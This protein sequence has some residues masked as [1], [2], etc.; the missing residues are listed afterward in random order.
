[1]QSG[2]VLVPL[3]TA[4]TGWLVGW[5]LIRVLLNLNPQNRSRPGFRGSSPSIQQELAEKVGG[6]VGE[7]L[8]AQELVGEKLSDPAHLE[9]LMPLIE[10]E[11]DEFLRVKLP[12][13]MPMI[14]MLVGERT[15]GELKSVFIAEL[16]ELFPVVMKNY[17][18]GLR[19]GMDPARLV[20][21]K[22]AALPAGKLE[23][24]V[25]VLVGNKGRKVALLGAGIGLVIGFVQVFILVNL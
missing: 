6:L 15:I 5:M 23:E 8:W 1:M 14:G 24:M 25:R 4:F 2:L 3:L 7:T 22:I 21:E 9:R 13:K 12:A 10:K 19:A 16:K 11:V 18:N 17:M 20:S